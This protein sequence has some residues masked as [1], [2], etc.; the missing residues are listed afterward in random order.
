MSRIEALSSGRRISAR[1]LFDQASRF[2]RFAVVGTSGVIVNNLVLF[3]LVERAHWVPV[4]ASLVATEVA[5]LSNF[6]LNDRWT[7][8]DR[9]AGRHW[10]SRAVQ[11]NVIVLGGLLVAVITLFALTS[12]F[13][14][15]YL[16][17]NLAGIAAGMLWNYTVNFHITWR[18]PDPEEIPDELWRKTQ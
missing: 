9:K 11:Y 13:H 7:F 8:A 12:W 6:T 1:G 4:L 16:I 2:T 17:A 5:I 3:L 10:S 14:I 18:R 15:H